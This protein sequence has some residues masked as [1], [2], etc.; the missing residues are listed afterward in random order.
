MTDP[1]LSRRPWAGGNLAQKIVM[2]KNNVARRIFYNPHKE[3][4]A[5]LRYE[6]A[7]GEHEV[8][9]PGTATVPINESNGILQTIIQKYTPD[10][11]FRLT[12]GDDIPQVTPDMFQLGEAEL[13]T[14]KPEDRAGVARAF[15][16]A[17]TKYVGTPEN[18]I[19]VGT[20][21]KNYIPKEA[22]YIYK[23]LEGKQ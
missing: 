20:R 10:V 13:A 17:A 1:T 22:I 18:A 14:L 9:N 23:H 16:A 4:E 21:I 2:D 19:I 15:L 12:L 3:Q 5:K 6:R 8:Y 11:K 7:H